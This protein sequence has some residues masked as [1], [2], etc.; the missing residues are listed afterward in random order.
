MKFWDFWCFSFVPLV[1]L[2]G[3]V[4]YLWKSVER[5]KSYRSGEIFSLKFPGC[6]PRMKFRVFWCF[7]FV[8]LV[9]VNRLVYYLLKSGERLKFYRWGYFFMEIPWVLPWN[10]ILSLLMSQFCSSCSG[11]S[12][13]VPLVK[14]GWTVKILSLG[15]FY[16]WNS[17][18]LP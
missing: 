13:G 16:H 12:I 5:L 2:N 10:D 14:I 8:P 18:G 17:P 1:Q 11:E 4:Y 3:L 6:S 9:Q 15:V 7:S